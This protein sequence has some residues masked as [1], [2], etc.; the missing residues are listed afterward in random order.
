MP[1]PFLNH[2]KVSHALQV[3][4]I[5]LKFHFLWQFYFFTKNWVRRSLIFLFIS[6][7]DAISVAILSYSKTTAWM[8]VLLYRSTGA[9]ACSGLHWIRP[10]ARIRASRR[11]RRQFVGT[12]DNWRTRAK[13]ISGTCVQSHAVTTLIELLTLY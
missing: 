2:L 11:R 5:L 7:H 1:A 12:R 9:C 3:K 10:R 13:R 6:S 8:F 4:S